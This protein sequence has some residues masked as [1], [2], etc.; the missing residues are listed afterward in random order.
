MTEIQNPGKIVW[1]LLTVQL[2]LPILTTDIY[3]PSLEAM[4]HY[5]LTSYQQVQLTLTCYFLM[6]SAAQLIYG[7]LSDRYGRKPLVLLS[8]LIYM[9]ATVCCMLARSVEWLIIGRAFQALGA[10]SA[11]LTFAIV[12]DLYEGE[13]AAKK[14]AYL[15]SVVALS[16]ILAPILGG[17]IQE[18]LSWQ[19]NFAFLGLVSS[20]LLIGSYHLLPETNHSPRLRSSFLRQFMG[21]YL[22]VLKNKHYLSHTLCLSFAIAGLF[23]YVSGAPYVLLELMKFSPAEFGWI[24]SAAALGYVLGAFLSG[25]LLSAFGIDFVLKM[26]IGSFIGGS[27]LMIYFC[28]YYPLNAFAFIAPQI[29]CEFGISIIVPLCMAKALQPIPQYAG[30]GSSFIGFLRFFFAAIASYLVIL[31][32]SSSAMPLALIIL[33]LSVLSL[34][35][36]MV[37]YVNFNAFQQRTIS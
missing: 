8:L 14:I 28:Y 4:S 16:P 34:G 25:K 2:A 6:F 30:A 1:T 18:N 27:I 20:F 35:S 32:L 22:H 12:R 9:L 13:S 7:P 29:I 37:G 19:W 5:F 36:L 11:V 26:G 24:F 3:L 31:A 33:G 23:T 21:D 17:Y 10:G 15:C